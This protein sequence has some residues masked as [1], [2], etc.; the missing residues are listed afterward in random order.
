MLERTIAIWNSSK[1][2]Y[3]VSFFPINA[4]SKQ[5]RSMRRAMRKPWDI[6]LKRFTTRLT[7]LKNYL[8]L[9]PGSSADKKMPPEELNKILLHAV[10]NGWENQAYLQGWEFEMKSYKDTCELLE[11]METEEKI[12]RGGSTSKNPTRAP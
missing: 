10:P 9:F 1:R 11:R 3:P 8:L 12:Y 5:K 7:E 2:V 6:S 4:L